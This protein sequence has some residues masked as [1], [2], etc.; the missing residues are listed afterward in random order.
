MEYLVTAAVLD[1]SRRLNFAGRSVGEKKRRVLGDADG[2]KSVAGRRMAQPCRVS[3]AFEPR[4]QSR[5]NFA[6][7]LC[8]SHSPRHCNGGAFLAGIG[9]LE[10][11]LAPR[12]RDRPNGGPREALAG[13]ELR[14]RRPPDSPIR[15]RPHRTPRGRIRQCSRHTPCAD[16]PKGYLRRNH[17]GRHTEC[18][19]YISPRERLPPAPIA[20][21]P[22]RRR[23]PTGR[24]PR[25]RVWA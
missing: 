18:A 12:H 25:P 13:T 1:P 20:S 11:V 4:G 24:P 21:A 16:R 2:L 3:G 10:A 17:C 9:S 6:E 14:N 19:C 22:H 15:H 23:R 7:V 8:R 5:S